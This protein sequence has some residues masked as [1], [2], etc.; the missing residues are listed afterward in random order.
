MS[1]DFR[2]GCRG[3]LADPDDAREDR[4]FIGAVACDPWFAIELR[5][6]DHLDIDGLRQ[7]RYLLCDHPCP[8]RYAR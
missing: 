7:T 4:E 6:P 1:A 3:F 8:W 5:L 2:E